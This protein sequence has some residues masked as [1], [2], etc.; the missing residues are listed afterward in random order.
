MIEQDEHSLIK[1]DLAGATENMPGSPR[2]LTAAAENDNSSEDADD[3]FPGKYCCSTF[4]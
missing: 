1:F 2:P 3:R 4:F